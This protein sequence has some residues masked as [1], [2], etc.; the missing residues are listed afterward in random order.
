MHPVLQ[1]CM[2]QDAIRVYYWIMGNATKFKLSQ[3]YNAD[4]K[5]TGIEQKKMSCCKRPHSL[6]NSWWR[7]AHP[8]CAGCLRSHCGNC[9]TGLSI[10]AGSWGARRGRGG[11]GT[12][13]RPGARGCWREVAVPKCPALSLLHSIPRSNWAT[14]CLTR[15]K[16]VITMLKD[17]LLLFTALHWQRSRK[18]GL[19][20]AEV[21]K[22]VVALF[23][24]S[25]LVDRVSQVAMF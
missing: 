21:P 1:S 8:H 5:V 11:R 9:G 3:T 20:L 4:F 15:E 13:V 23:R 7:S 17:A 22:C 18:V 6:M 12:A 19:T 10:R 24:K 25:D 16:N 2:S 14:P